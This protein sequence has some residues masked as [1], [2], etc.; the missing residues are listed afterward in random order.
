M[1]SVNS[2][3]PESITATEAEFQAPQEQKHQQEQTQVQEQH[4]GETKHHQEQQAEGQEYQQEHQ[5]AE[6]QEH[7]QEQ[8]QAEGQEHQQE[9][10]QTEGQEHQQ[11]QQQ[12]ER[13]EHHQEEQQTEG[14]EHQ[15]EQQ[16]AERQEHHQEEQQTEGQEHQ[17]EQQQVQSQ[18]EM[19]VNNIMYINYNLTFNIH[20][21]YKKAENEAKE[22][23]EKVENL[24][25]DNQ[26]L[27]QEKVPDGLSSLTEPKSITKG[28]IA[29]N[30]DIKNKVQDQVKNSEEQAGEF[31][32]ASF[33]Y[34]Q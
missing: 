6:G 34:L 18:A 33:A 4:S 13:Q 15:Q 29:S 32:P 7:Q 17:Q 21:I 1:D 27:L 10:Q 2:T 8:Q 11:E 12:A 30:D 20:I 25:T 23:V 16:Q 14:Q 22:I 28:A 9:E 5:Q 19:K 3:N 31:G 26:P 24:E